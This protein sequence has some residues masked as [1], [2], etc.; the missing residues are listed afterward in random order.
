VTT[1]L[2]ADDSEMSRKVL[3]ILLSRHGYHVLEAEDGDEGLGIMRSAHPDLAI[4]DLL[5]P[6]MDGFE[7]VRAVREDASIAET[8]IIF[9]TANF[10]PKEV[11]PL[12]QRLGV[13]HTLL[14]SSSSAEV[15]SAVR[16]AE[17]SLTPPDVSVGE[18]E[19]RREHFRLISAKLAEEFGSLA[20][21]FGDLLSSTA[22]TPLDTDVKP[23]HAGE[24]NQADRKARGGDRPAEADDDDDPRSK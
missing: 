20:T 10:P 15:L 2:I 24:P 3:S 18:G 19:F 13:R 4:I 22:P 1:V 21:A 14:K 11:L 12:A 23:E 6:V 16:E 8:P 5:M 17:M 9:L 7:F